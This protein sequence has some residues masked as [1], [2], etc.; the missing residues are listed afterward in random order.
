MAQPTTFNG[1][2]YFRDTATFAVA[3]V[4]PASIIS[5]THI[6]AGAD[7]DPAKMGHRFEKTISQKLGVDVATEAHVAHA[8]YGTTGTLLAFRAGA[9]TPAGSATTVAVDLKKN[10]TTVLSS[11]I[12]LNNSQAAYEMVNGTISSASLAADD[13]LTVHFTL[14]GTNEPQ[15]VFC[16]LIWNEDPA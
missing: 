13:V 10:G 5:D 8:V 7:I 16:Q 6:S 4:L 14:T 1:T 12:T 9:V 11:T 2:T 3:P 15:G